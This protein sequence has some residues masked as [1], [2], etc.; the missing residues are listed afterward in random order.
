MVLSFTF[1]IIK[2]TK[3]GSFLAN[4]LKFKFFVCFII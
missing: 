3:T 4:K 2:K 1:K